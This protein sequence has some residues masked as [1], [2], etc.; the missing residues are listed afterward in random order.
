M[1]VVS[2]V[3]ND[4]GMID[5][6]IDVPLFEARSMKD[7][8]LGERDLFHWLR[9]ARSFNV[10]NKTFFDLL[11]MYGSAYAA[12]QALPGLASRGGRR[13][14]KPCKVE[15][16]EQE[17][18]NVKKFG[19]ELIPYCD[20]RYPKLLKQISDSPPVITVFSHNFDLYNT[21]TTLSVV[22]ARNASI[23]SHNF[24][25]KIVAELS[26]KQFVI[27]SGLARGIDTVAHQTS[28][29]TGTVAVV[30]GGIDSFYPPENR[31][32]LYQIKDEG[33]AIITEMPYGTVPKGQH[34]PMR[35]RIIS[36]MSYGTLIV[37]ATLGSGS[38][39]TARYALEQNREVF[40]VPGFPSYPGSKG[41]NHLLKQGANLVETSDD[42]VEILSSI[43]EEHDFNNQYV[44]DYRSVDFV[45]SMH[46]SDRELS[47][48]RKKIMDI[49]NSDPVSINDIVEFTSYPVSLVIVIIVELELAGKVVRNIGNQVVRIYE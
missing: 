49:L 26:N 7:N 42:I 21:K 44:R 2:A 18:H 29:K 30:A 5:A 35:N 47:E 46:W 20:P 15:Y 12:L 48:A 16:I 9:L 36:G 8:I 1:V 34:F 3:S 33:G 31:D 14:F 19:A 23:N 10:G 17:I 6:D 24:T 41:T 37:E 27:V 13:N 11:S 25:K 38:L 39:I 4:S 28:C 43:V 45:S 22:G 40:A 32:L